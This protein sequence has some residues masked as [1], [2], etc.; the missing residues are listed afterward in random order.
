MSP[1]AISLLL[2]MAL[3]ALACACGGG[4]QQLSAASQPAGQVPPQIQSALP[5]LPSDRGASLLAESLI[6]GKASLD[7]SA[8]A[9]EQ[10]PALLLD[11]AGAGVWQW[12]LY[13][14]SPTPDHSLDSVNVL[15]DV[16]QGSA[17]W[18]GLADYEAGR[19]QLFGPYQG[20]KTLLADD[21]AYLSPGGNLYVVALVGDG[22]SATVNAL[23]VRTISPGNT[24]PSAALQ[25]DVSSG[26]APLSVNFD[27]SAS[28][29]S[30]G[31]IIEYAWDWDGDGSYDSITDGPEI[32]HV[33]D[34][35]GIF[36]TRMRVTDEFFGRASAV[37]Q[38]SVTVAGNNQPNAVLGGNSSGTA[39]LT[40][41]FDGS[42]SDP[43]DPGDSIVSYQWDFDGDLSF[44]AQGSSPFA[45][46]VYT[47][48][49][50]FNA[51]LRV[52]DSAGNQGESNF[53]NIV[54]NAAPQ[55]VLEI[56][57]DSADTGEAVDLSG[58]QSS[59]P[60][61]SIVN[62][63]WDTNGDGSYDLDSNASPVV[64][65][66][67]DVPGLYTLKLR[68][69]DNNGAQAEASASLAVHGWLTPQYPDMFHTGTGNE[70]SLAEIDGKPAIAYYGA[71]DTDLYY[72]RAADSKGQFWVGSPVRVN[73]VQSDSTGRWPCLRKVFGRPAVAFHDSGNDDLMYCRADDPLGDSWPASI[74]VDSAGDTG[75]HPS[76]LVVDGVPHIAYQQFENL[77]LRYVRASDALGGAWDAPIILD[78]SGDVGYWPCL[79]IV[80]GN[81][82]VSYWDDGGGAVMFM[83]A[84][85][86]GGTSWGAPVFVDGPTSLNS[87]TWLLDVNGN[88]AV[89]YED[90]SNGKQW[91]NRSPDLFGGNFMTATEMPSANGSP[92]SFSMAII[93]G[94]PA[95][96]FYDN[97][98]M[99]LKYSRALN[100]NGTVWET[101]QTLDTSGVV[102]GF[103]SMTEISG[104][105]GIS[106]YDSTFSRLKYVWGY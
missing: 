1:R 55:A 40:V 67:F 33:F 52:T 90:N 63:E 43:G 36:D 61:G 10:G 27:A 50:S 3:A 79:A 66:S 15:L 96:A 12:A 54:V 83:R 31:N 18:L 69:T 7:R 58:S 37:A 68:V 47:E 87:P 89:G 102:G 11:S 85:T 53:L 45:S 16:S 6:Q 82:A 88:P 98:G 49:G 24:P 25:A 86:A 106:Y 28:S 14:F 29:D 44:D 81:P 19:W 60:G 30:D 17:V 22:Q 38:I 59:D 73:S 71:T 105:V 100:K 21:P 32:S 46:H 94:N 34:Q 64:T 70:S 62:Y 2:L 4:S 92:A 103:S 91:L 26:D 9:Q 74:I 78:D 76:M 80:A 104:G 41:N 77:Q 99:D 13:G 57:P 95:I 56:L 35:P 42:L 65:L 72:V 75:Q 23:S 48:A 51:L 101:P 20:S 93:D 97:T 39:P 5:E 84:N 8:A